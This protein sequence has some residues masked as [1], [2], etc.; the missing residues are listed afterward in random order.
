MGIERVEA[1]ENNNVSK[2]WTVE[3]L[4]QIEEKYKKMLKILKND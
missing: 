2:R 3:E 4:K 1:L